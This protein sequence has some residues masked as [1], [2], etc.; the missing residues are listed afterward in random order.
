MRAWD[1]NRF[2]W[3][4]LAG[5]IKTRCLCIARWKYPVHIISKYIYIYKYNMFFLYIYIYMYATYILPETH[6]APEHLMVKKMRAV[7]FGGQV[8]PNFYGLV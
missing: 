6:L 7:P 1:L 5:K 3:G 4:I 2:L 8:G